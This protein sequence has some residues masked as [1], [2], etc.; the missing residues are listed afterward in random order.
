M[1]AAA[2]VNSVM[3]SFSNLKRCR[4][5]FTRVFFVSALILWPV[6]FSQNSVANDPEPAAGTNGFPS[7]PEVLGGKT[8]E[9]Q[10]GQDIY[11]LRAIH[12]RYASYWPDL[13]GANV[14][15]TDYVLAPEKLLRFVNELGEA[16]RDR[17]D[18][19]ACT[20]LALITSDPSFY[21]NTD[22][23]HPEILKE[24]ARALIK[25]GPAGRNAL[26]S[27]F[28]AAHYGKDPASLEV[29]AE[30]IGEEKPG[31]AEFVQVLSTTAFDFATTNGSFYPRCITAAVKNLLCLSGGPPAV[32]AHLKEAEMFEN[33]GRFQAVVDGIAAAHASQ[34]T[35]NL[36]L[37]QPKIE[38]KLA[39]LANSPGG[40]RDDLQELNRIIKRTVADFG[41]IGSKRAS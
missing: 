32:Q 38:A 36:L 39:G 16:M 20:N 30:A 40:Y 6:V 23:S 8:F 29:L 12:D 10:T 28:S 2:K 7:V 21:A 19:V 25:I 3:M 26:A 17:N 33:P 35:T 18:A 11:F 15:L 31:D 37:I 34:L 22:A 41:G 14:T 24:A 27:A 4:A 13:L 5:V 9:N 1:N